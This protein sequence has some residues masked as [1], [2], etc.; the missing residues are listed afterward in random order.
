MVDKP[1]RTKRKAKVPAKRLGP[2]PIPVDMAEVGKLAAIMCT[3]EEI[4]AVLGCSV[5]TLRRQPDFEAV[6]QTGRDEGK[7]SLRRRQWAK[8]Q[9][10]HPTMLI[11]MG[12]QIL[13]QTDKTLR[14]SENHT[15]IELVRSVKDV[16][17]AATL[18]PIDAELDAIALPEPE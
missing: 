6:M 12:K 4:A 5:R 10:G 18:P 2:K 16:G 14:Q 8:A 1:K 7:A 9:E 3:Q 15:I 11:W 13:G 17:L